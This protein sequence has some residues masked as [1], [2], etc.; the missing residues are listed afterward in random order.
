M[1]RGF[2]DRESLRRNEGLTRIFTDDTDQEQAT[3]KA[4]RGAGSLHY[5]T[6]LDEESQG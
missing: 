2:R 3:A 4:N 6:M 1:Q 5:G